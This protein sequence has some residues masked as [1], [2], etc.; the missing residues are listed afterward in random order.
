MTAYE[1]AWT[2]FIAAIPAAVPRF[3]GEL[4]KDAACNR[5]GPHYPGEYGCIRS[6]VWRCPPWLLVVNRCPKG[7]EHRAG[8]GCV[9]DARGAAS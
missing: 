5:D 8:C 7:Q 3:G 2:K 4:C 6:P 1:E 9:G